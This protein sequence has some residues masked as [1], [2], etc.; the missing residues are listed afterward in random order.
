LPIDTAPTV[1][2]PP[3]T[4]TA[5]DTRPNGA[6]PAGPAKATA[7]DVVVQSPAATPPKPATP[8]G[9]DAATPPLQ[10]TD[11]MGKM[12]ALYQQAANK[13][14]GIDTYIARFTRREMVNG[15]QMPQ[16]ILLCRFRKEPFSVYFKW[17]A[18]T[19]SE[20]REIIY[21]KGMN[22]NEILVKTGRRDSL[23]PLQTSLPLNSERATANS[24]HT[25]DEAG[26]GRLLDG[27]GEGL[28]SQEHKANKLGT[29]QY[30]GPQ[31]R[32]EAATPMECILQQIPPGIE[33]HL[34]RGGQRYWFFCTD[35][36]LQECGLPTLVITYDEARREVEYYFHDLFNLNVVSPQDF[37]PKVVWAKR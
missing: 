5:T 14:G 2:M 33:K 17:L 15:R 10:S 35:T 8:V 20:G 18:G 32:P 36:R 31:Q 12:K 7:T 21:V 25:M 9:L 22:N 34:Q 23:I 24:R 16:D 26:L 29:F 13:F 27:L 28:A 3:G 37:D 19:A 11:D 30:L 4:A 6:S 1:G